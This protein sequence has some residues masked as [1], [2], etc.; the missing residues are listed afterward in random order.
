MIK[1]KEI[2]NVGSG[3]FLLLGLKLTGA[4]L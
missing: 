1:V 3:I 4:Y 2:I